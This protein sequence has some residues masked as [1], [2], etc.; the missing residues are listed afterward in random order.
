MRYLTLIF[1]AFTLSL[2]ASAQKSALDRA[3]KL[4]GRTDRLQDARS[5]LKSAMDSTDTRDNIDT[6][7]IAGKIE[8]AAYDKNS[9][10]N[11]ITPGSVN[12]IEV[13]HQLLNGYHYFDQ[14]IKMD[15]LKN[16]KGV[17]SHKY[18]R[19]LKKKIADKIADFDYAASVLFNDPDKKNYLAAY[20]AYMIYADSPY[21]K[22]GSQLPDS[23]KTKIYFTAGRAAWNDGDYEKSALAFGKARHMEMDDPMACIYEIA[24]WLQ[25]QQKDPSSEKRAKQAILEAAADGYAKFGLS[26]PYIIHNLI[27]T[28]IH[29]GQSPQAIEFLSKAIAENPDQA[30]LYGLRAFV[31]DYLKDDDNAEKDYRQYASMQNVNYD[32][33]RDAINKIVSIGSRKWNDLELK[34]PQLSAKKNE[35]KTNYFLEAKKWIERMK[36]QSNHPGDFNEVLEIIY[37]HINQ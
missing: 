7:Y 33:M 30:E 28:M 25:V 31:Y 12:Q 27:N 29:D 11:S 4:I 24:S 19:E 26:N 18:S 3:K 15:T 9:R 23:V 8:W 5:L 36:G 21:R 14:A 1:L 6:Y 34:D 16:K 10:A 20:D 22:K 17:V 35:L 2:S 32:T 13:A 37:F